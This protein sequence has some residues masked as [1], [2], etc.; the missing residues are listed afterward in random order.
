MIGANHSLHNYSGQRAEFDYSDLGTLLLHYKFSEEGNVF[1]DSS[2]T[3]AAENGDFVNGITD[4]SGNSKHLE[5]PS[6]T[7]QQPT[8]VITGGQYENYL[9]FDSGQNDK[10]FTVTGSGVKGTTST[11]N[12][13]SIFIVLD[14]DTI[15]SNEPYIF[16]AEDNND[17]FFRFTDSDT[18]TFKV[19]DGLPGGGN[20]VGLNLTTAAPTTKKFLLYA[21]IN[22][23]KKIEAGVNLELNTKGAAV[24]TNDKAFIGTIGSSGALGS[25]SN[26]QGKMYE[27]IAFDG[28]LGDIDT[29]GTKANILGNHLIE[30]FNNEKE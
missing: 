24:D 1:E 7:G 16:G 15:G 25:G 17:S 28:A 2:R 29:A 10:A 21:G 23:D 14:I 20:P 22:S 27:F 13:I 19:H 18:I 6:G 3:D 4:V 26:L 9:S 11:S 5:S 30:K 12:E 8:Y